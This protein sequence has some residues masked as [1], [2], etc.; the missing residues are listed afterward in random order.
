LAGI[1]LA[2]QLPA[3]LLIFYGRESLLSSH[4][5]ASSFYLSIGK[6]FYLAHLF[7]EVTKE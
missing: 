5:F 2:G 3:I 7:F 6:H 4:F 1:N